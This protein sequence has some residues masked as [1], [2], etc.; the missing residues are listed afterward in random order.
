M[1][2]VTFQLWS[3]ISTSLGLY[4]HG[5]CFAVEVDIAEDGIVREWFLTDFP[6]QLSIS[7]CEDS[8]FR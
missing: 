7:Y 6:P 3:D 8:N 2:Y 4:V 5:V 1:I